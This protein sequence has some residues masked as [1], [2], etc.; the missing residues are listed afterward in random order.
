MMAAKQLISH[1]EQLFVVGDEAAPAQ[2][3]ILLNKVLR[4]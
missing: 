2:A 1:V 3:S 4:G